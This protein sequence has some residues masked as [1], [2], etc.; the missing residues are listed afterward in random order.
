MTNIELYIN[1]RL[2]DITSDISIRLNRLILNPSELNTKDAQYSYS[3]SL[4]VTG[5]NNHIFSY[6]FIEETSGKFNKGY[7]ARMY[8]NG[9]EVFNGSFKLT[10]I[11]NERYKGN[12]Y[13]EDYKSIK[14]IFGE[15]K[16]NE[17]APF[18]IPFKDFSEYITYYNTQARNSIQMAIFPYILYG[19][20]PKVSSQKDAEDYSAR[21]IWD[22]TVRM[23]MQDLPP[24]INVLGMLRH[25]FE[26]RGLSLTGS[27]FDD[28]R[29]TRLYMSYRNETDYVQPW[30]YGR[31][32]RMR[33]SGFWTNTLNYSKFEKNPYMTSGEDGTCY[34][35]D[36]LNATNATVNILEDN[37]GNILKKNTV[38][39][40]GNAWTETQILIPSNGF[41]KVRL[42]VDLQVNSR[43]NWRS[44]EDPQSGIQFVSGNASG[45]T[46]ANSFR[47]KRYEIKLV[48][49]KKTGDFGLAA[50]RVDKT[51]YRDNLNQNN[52]FD[53]ENIPKYFPSPITTSN[54]RYSEVMIVD[55]A[56]NPNAVLGVSFGDRHN[57]DNRNPRVPSYSY[58]T[59]GT[60]LA[61]RTGLSWNVSSNPSDPANVILP[62]VGYQRYGQVGDI[63]DD[64]DIPYFTVPESAKR[65]DKIFDTNGLLIDAPAGTTTVIASRIELEANKQFTIAVPASSGWQG[66]VRH[67][68][69]FDETV[70]QTGIVAPEIEGSSYEAIIDTSTMGRYISF[71]LSLEPDYDITNV[72]KI[73]E[74]DGDGDAIGWVNTSRFKID[75]V[76][77]PV[78]YASRGYYKGVKTNDLDW[79]A[80]GE[81]NAIVWLEAGEILTITS[82][83]D[84]GRYK[85]NKS[86]GKYGMTIHDIDFELDIIPFRTE[87][88]WS[89]VNSEGRSTGVM[90]W[91]DASNFDTDFI[92]LT[93][94]L[95]ADTRTDDFIDQ[96]CKAF[97]L[98]ISQVSASDFRLD[99]K[100]RSTNPSA[101]Y[102]DL[103]HIVN[104]KAKENAPL[105]LPSMYKLGFTID[106]EEEGFIRTGEDGGGTYETGAIGGAITEQKSTFS[107]NW[108]KNIIKTET[109]GNV[110]LPIP[111]ISKNEVWIEGTSYYNN[112][113]RRFTT[114]AQR[115]FYFD[116]TLNDLG[117][118]FYFNN[119]ALQIA[120]V[121]NALDG[122]LV[123]NYKNEAL[124]ILSNYFTIIA[125]ADSSYTDIEAFLTPEEYY[126]LDGNRYVRLNSDLYLC[127]QIEGFDPTGRNA[128]KIRLIRKL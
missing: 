124:T 47:K 24:A 5:N 106:E 6:S 110:V 101:A 3:I 20:I 112:M 1:N 99:V 8:I 103:E 7:A 17:N 92:N 87:K 31:Q 46:L 23:N 16:L 13:I 116:G 78:S 56:Q 89:K 41:Y 118:T 75:V 9:I 62:N 18:W 64:I 50:A 21:N 52:I 119:V 123:L 96:L 128:T 85:Q 40:N 36:L 34:T 80:D 95:H 42:K 69:T 104:I 109:T 14:D 43:S 37:G 27:A 83:S 33:L 44:G 53:T 126:A 77:A 30:N 73:K 84:Q 39:S 91:N 125:N 117:A 107:Y 61:G 26:S 15:T 113:L 11:T 98:K 70:A 57:V 4:P 114:Q 105:G 35:S 90:D 86:S 121:K 45:D 79:Q 63:G 94:F 76:N 93:G 10:G 32:A 28:D 2:C 108:Y 60:V 122:R 74:I 12:L 111:V 25:I 29:L 81:V 71:E 48:S 66:S 59:F 19:L 55:P 88:E 22:S 58:S 102:I 100:Q 51:Y 115:F 120:K 49:D 65:Q 127:A 38:D 67:Y 68:N 97:N 82:T 72:I 54:G